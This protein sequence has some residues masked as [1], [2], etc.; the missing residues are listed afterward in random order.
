MDTGTIK[1][2][3]KKELSRKVLPSIQ[4]EGF[5]YGGGYGGLTVV[6]L[7]NLP[8]EEVQFDSDEPQS[9]CRP[10][11]RQHL[12]LQTFNISPRAGGILI[13]LEGWVALERVVTQPSIYFYDNPSS[14]RAR[15]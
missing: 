12:I 5:F 14:K 3:A 1:L 15:L 2:G 9:C 13:V 8:R 11:A 7:E 10:T 4:L 6:N